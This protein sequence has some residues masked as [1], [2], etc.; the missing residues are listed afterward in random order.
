MTQKYFFIEWL[1]DKLQVFI[2]IISLIFLNVCAMVAPILSHFE[3]CSLK[4]DTFEKRMMSKSNYH[5]KPVN[6]LKIADQLSTE[7]NIEVPDN[8]HLMYLTMWHTPHL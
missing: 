3:L 6:N 1:N 5:S 7:Q 2:S 4:D 8:F